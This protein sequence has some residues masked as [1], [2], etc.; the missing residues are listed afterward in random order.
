MEVAILE[1]FP[2]VFNPKFLAN[3]QNKTASQSLLVCCKSSNTGLDFLI[4]Q[5]T[6]ALASF[7]KQKDRLQL[8]V[9]QKIHAFGDINAW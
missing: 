8:A 5:K 4:V 9:F 2:F 7:L 3:R 6:T 1:R